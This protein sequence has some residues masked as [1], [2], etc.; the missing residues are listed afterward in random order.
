MP[1]GPVFD[2]VGTSGGNGGSWGWND[3]G[4]TMNRTRVSSDTIMMLDCVRGYTAG[5]QSMALFN[6]DW[7]GYS[8]IR[9]V[10]TGSHSGKSASIAFFDQ[11]CETVY[12]SAL[13]H[14]PHYWISGPG[15]LGNASTTTIDDLQVNCGNTGVPRGYWTAVKG[16]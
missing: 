10:S 12:R 4:H 16:D 8:Y 2:E 13:L 5:E 3:Q 15:S 6:N 9:N 14:D 11:H 7:T 1:F